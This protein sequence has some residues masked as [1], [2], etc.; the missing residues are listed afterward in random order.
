MPDVL[1]CVYSPCALRA[2]LTDVLEANT[3]R[4]A[5]TCGWQLGAG[6]RSQHNHQAV[7]MEA[8]G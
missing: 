7:T 4:H 3:A 6:F 8:A 5:C 2:C 1:A